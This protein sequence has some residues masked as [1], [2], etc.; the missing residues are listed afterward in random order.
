MMP[1]VDELQCGDQV[2]LEAIIG[3]VALIA[4]YAGY[5]LYTISIGLC[6]ALTAFSIIGGIGLQWYRGVTDMDDLSGQNI[7]SA[8]QIRQDLDI[9]DQQQIIKLGIVAFFCLIWGVM[10]CLVC[11]KTHDKIHKILGFIGGA[12]IG[13]AAV[14]LV[15]TLASSQVQRISDQATISEYEG[16]EM[17]TMLA[18]GVPIAGMV[19]YATRNL[20]KYVLMAATAFLGSFVG[21][22]LLAHVLDC[23][24]KTSVHPLIILGVAVLSAV[25]AFVFQVNMTPEAQTKSAAGS[26]GHL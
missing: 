14:A 2:V 20:I 19:G 15:V 8:T 1:F 4:A 18:A 16:W 6:G 25:A 11:V 12:A 7:A 17:Y 22:G 26:E 24:T 13:F 5:R 3:I 10:G 9:E 21:I 23:A